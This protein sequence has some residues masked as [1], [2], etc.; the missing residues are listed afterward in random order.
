MTSQQ[1]NQKDHQEPMTQNFPKEPL[2]GDVWPLLSTD[3]TDQRRKRMEAVAARRTNHVRLVIQDIHDPHN[4]AACMRS[5]EAFGILN[6]DVIN[7]YQKFKPS[8]VSRGSAGWLR[9]RQWSE[10]AKCVEALREEGYLIAAGMPSQDSTSLHQMPVSQ[11]VA[12]LFGNEHRGVAPEWMD[13]VDI[14]FTIPMVGMVES[15][16]ISVSAALTLSEVS[17]RAREEVGDLAYY[18]KPSQ[19]NELLGE[20]IA[21]KTNRFDRV[22]AEKRDR[23]AK[24]S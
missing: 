6:V 12:V 5:A 4:I 11:K 7:L 10:I 1:V 14:K 13:H 9:V 16:N 23:V 15:L 19:Q 3:I 17:R 2:S 20:W 8:S 22:I 21:A 18:L 24:N